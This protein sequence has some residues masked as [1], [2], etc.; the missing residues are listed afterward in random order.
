MAQARAAMLNAE[1]NFALIPYKM[2]KILGDTNYR[3]I[4]IGQS[5]YWNSSTG[6]IVPVG[7]FT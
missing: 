1:S 2:Q 6:R 5:G 4:G 7:M 3:N